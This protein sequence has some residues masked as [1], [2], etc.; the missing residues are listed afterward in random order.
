MHVHS[1]HY[2]ALGSRDRGV[3]TTRHD[4][5][6]IIDP[7]E[8]WRDLRASR[9]RFACP[10]ITRAICDKYFYSILYLSLCQQVRYEGVDKVTLVS[11]RDDYRHARC[12]KSIR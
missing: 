9:E 12:L 3:Q 7:P 8:R 10:V 1:H 2:G 5:L 6:R 11:T 4:L